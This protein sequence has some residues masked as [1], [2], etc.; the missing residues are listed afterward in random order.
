MYGNKLLKQIS[1][2]QNV[3]ET[4]LYF[5]TQD[6]AYIVDCGWV[7]TYCISIHRYLSDTLTDSYVI[8]DF[9]TKFDVTWSLMQKLWRNSVKPSQAEEI[10]H[11][12]LV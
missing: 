8:S 12:H 2:I 7:T 3:E 5:L 1:S 9:S 10:I 6:E 4:V 11:D